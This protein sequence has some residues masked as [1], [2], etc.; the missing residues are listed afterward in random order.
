MAVYLLGQRMLQV[1]VGHKPLCFFE[2]RVPADMRR[3]AALGNQNVS[4][5]KLTL[6]FPKQKPSFVRG[7]GI[8]FSVVLIVR[9]L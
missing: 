6:L 8:H 4:H 1:K 5:P 3:S 2:S 9:F 7:V